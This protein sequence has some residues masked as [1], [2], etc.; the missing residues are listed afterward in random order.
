LVKA[1]LGDGRQPGSPRGRAGVVGDGESRQP[2][3]ARTQALLHAP[4]AYVL[5]RSGGWIAVQLP[6]TGRASIA[7][8]AVPRAAA[9][10]RGR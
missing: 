9:T 1:H 8:A 2:P 6:A 5:A 3:G 10:W 4:P 7:A